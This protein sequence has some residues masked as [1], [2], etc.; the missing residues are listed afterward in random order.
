[1]KRQLHIEH[2]RHQ[3]RFEDDVLPWDTPGETTKKLRT[4][5]NK[6]RQ[7]N[8]KLKALQAEDLRTQSLAQPN[9]DASVIIAI[10]TSREDVGKLT[11]LGLKT[12]LWDNTVEQHEL[13]LRARE[14]LWFDGQ[15][16]SSIFWPEGSVSS[17]EVASRLMGGLAATEEWYQLCTS[18]HRMI[19]PVAALLPSLGQHYEICF[20]K[21]LEKAP[22][23]PPAAIARCVEASVK[24]GAPSNFQLRA[25]WKDVTRKEAFVIIADE[26]AVPEK[27]RPLKRKAIQ[28]GKKGRP[29]SF[30]QIVHSLSIWG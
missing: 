11:L 10:A 6:E 25:N 17:F 18:E 14:R 5:V 13:L 7:L 9:L 2:R 27:L 21:S 4:H 20:H 8:E 22:L 30:V 29:C 3:K 19:R 16:D 28:E 24:I 1:M 12:V 23:E 26:L 15:A